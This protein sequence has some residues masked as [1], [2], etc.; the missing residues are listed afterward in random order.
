MLLQKVLE[1]IVYGG[2]LLQCATS[3][4]SGSIRD[5]SCKL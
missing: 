1:H 2:L 4:W 5:P 3:L